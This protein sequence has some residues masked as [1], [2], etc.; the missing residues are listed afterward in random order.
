MYIKKD[1]SAWSDSLQ[2]SAQVKE[3]KVCLKEM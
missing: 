2:M 3:T 1:E